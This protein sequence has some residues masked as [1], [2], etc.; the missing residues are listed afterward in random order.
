MLSP[1]GMSQGVLDRLTAEGNR[2]RVQVTRFKGLGEMPP[3]QLKETTMKPG[4][5]TLL[6]VVLPDD[7]GQTGELVEQLMGRKPEAR[8]HYIQ[9]N[10]RFVTDLDL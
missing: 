5:R 10:A 2:S 8:F 3:S 1:N 7:G 9:E 4:S 6:R